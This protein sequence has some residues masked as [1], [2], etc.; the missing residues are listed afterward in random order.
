MRTKSVFFLALA[1]GCGLVAAVGV[2]QVLATRDR[3][4]PAPVVEMKP[5]VVAAEDI[6][7][8]D[9]VKITQIKLED[10]PKSK[11]PEGALLKVE[12]VE[13]RR[14]KT[15][16]YKGSPILDAQLLEKGAV[17]AGAAPWIPK[18]YRVVSVKVDPV[19]GSASML[20]PSD[21]VDVVVH[22]PAMPSKGIP[23][24]YTRTILQNVKVFAVDDKY[25]LTGEEKNQ[26]S[27][28]AKTVSL[29]VTP[30]QAEIL[31]AA[32]ELGQIRL[33]MRGLGD[34]DPVETKGIDPMELLGLPTQ[35]GDPE[36]EIVPG[37]D[38]LRKEDA[39]AQF[40]STQANSTATTAVSTRNPGGQTWAMRL[41]LGS[42]VNDVVLEADTEHV[43]PDSM[44]TIWRTAASAASPFPGNNSSPTATQPTSETSPSQDGGWLPPTDNPV[45]ERGSDQ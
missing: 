2:Q 35:G 43:W 37:S 44:G 18:G 29:L 7:M 25:A 26:K 42:Q 28:Q 9:P 17:D 12:D 32:T 33:V 24:D 23:K 8:G 15:K 6:P 3:A 36:K 31:T 1:L 39:F 4:A 20:R 5:I 27:I 11:I 19:S 10:W 45:P 14:T 40:L 30:E 38:T 34:N 41:L 16:I 21:R 22:F 13:G